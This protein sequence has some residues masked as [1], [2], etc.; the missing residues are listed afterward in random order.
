MFGFG[1]KKYKKVDVIQYKGYYLPIF[2]NGEN[3][4]VGEPMESN[5]DV[6]ESKI[7]DINDISKIKNAIYHIVNG[8]SN[9]NLFPESIGKIKVSVKKKNKI[10]EDN[11]KTKYNWDVNDSEKNRILEMHLNATKNH[12]MNEQRT[13]KIIRFTMSVLPEKRPNSI[14]GRF[15]GEN[16]FVDFGGGYLDVPSKDVI[17]NGITDPDTV[18]I[19][20]EFNAEQ[21]FTKLYVPTY[22][23]IDGNITFMWMECVNQ[24]GKILPSKTGLTYKVQ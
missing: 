7:Y 17:E 3:T 14:M 16:L 11:M 2:S 10:F 9:D 15:D 20:V 12:Y 18:E 19:L 1:E 21:N 22:Q 23:N 8:K 24:N 4:F 6:Y 5:D 13:T